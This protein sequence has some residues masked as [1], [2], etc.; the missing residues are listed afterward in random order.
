MSKASKSFYLLDFIFRKIFRKNSGV[1][2]PVHFTATI[3]NPERL[4]IGKNTFPGDSPGVYINAKNGI[5]VGD[6]T[7]IGPNVVLVS[8]NHDFFDNAVH[9]DARPIRIGKN[10]WIGANAVILPEVELGENTIV[11]AGAVVT[12]SFPDGFC[13]VAG[14][15]AKVIRHLRD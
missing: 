14:N 7:N 8:A 5:F 12:T 13:I 6:N 3:H 10:S 2:Y 1:K 9:Q 15:P 4:V 11:G